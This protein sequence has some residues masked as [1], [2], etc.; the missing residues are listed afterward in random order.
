MRRKSN[1]VIRF[2]R[3]ERL[4]AAEF[5]HTSSRLAQDQDQRR[6]QPRSMSTRHGARSVRSTHASSRRFRFA[7][8]SFRGFARGTA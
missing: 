4:V 7:F 3:A 5:T 8:A 1:G 2:E 6:P